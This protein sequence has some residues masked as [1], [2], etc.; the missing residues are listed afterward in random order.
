[1]RRMMLEQARHTNRLLTAR[2]RTFCLLT[3][4]VSRVPDRTPDATKFSIGPLAS[5]STV[6]TAHTITPPSPT[7]TAWHLDGGAIDDWDESSTWV[8]LMTDFP[9]RIIHILR[10][11]PNGLT[12]KDI[13]ERLGTTQRNVSSRLSKLAA[14]GIIGRVRGTVAEHGTKGAIYRAPCDAAQDAPI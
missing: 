3:I 2:F 8:E 13:A 10:S 6:L 11:C 9:N 14:Y 7:F 5:E 1:M 12:S 4:A